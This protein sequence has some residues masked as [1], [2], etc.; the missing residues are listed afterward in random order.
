[1]TLNDEW[2]S[3]VFDGLKRV[4]GSSQLGDFHY[5][6]MLFHEGRKI[7]KEQRTLLE[8][9]G[10][11]LSQIQGEPPAYGIIWHGKECTTSRIKLGAGLRKSEQTVRELREMSDS[12]SPP[13][14][15]L[16]DHCRVCELVVA[17]S[18][19]RRW[20]GGPCRDRTYDQRIK[21]S[22]LLMFS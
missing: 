14:L 7:G 2:L 16:N 18:H 19:N 20:I 11:L 12:P 3:L 13:R 8:V 6:P 10:M 4:D 17:I 21:D 15:I 9:F 22:I 5:I 1:M